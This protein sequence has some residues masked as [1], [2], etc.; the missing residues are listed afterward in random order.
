MD[1]TTPQQNTA[2]P[3]LCTMVMDGLDSLSQVHDL[4]FE[5]YNP[6]TGGSGRHDSVATE[7][8]LNTPI[9]KDTGVEFNF[10]PTDI[11]QEA[12]PIT[13]KCTTILNVLCFDC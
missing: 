5:L 11:T 10:G 4:G 2:D 13:G 8:D 12:V 7:G 1:N 3:M 9:T 6:P